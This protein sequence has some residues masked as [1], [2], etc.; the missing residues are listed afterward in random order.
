MTDSFLPSDLG[1]V[2][3]DTLDIGAQANSCS[4]TWG[5][6]DG[7]RLV[8]SMQLA[9]TQSIGSIGDGGVFTY[10]WTL[11]NTTN[12][13]SAGVGAGFTDALPSSLRVAAMP[14]AAS[15]CTAF[16][17]DALA[18]GTVVTV[19]GV[20]VPAG[21]TF[22]VSV[23]ITN[24]P[25]DSNASCAGNPAAFTNSDKNITDST[26]LENLIV[27]QCVLVGQTNTSLTVTKVA[28]S[29]PVTAGVSFDFVI[30]VTDTLD[31]IAALDV[32][33]TDILDPALIFNSIVASDSGTTDSGT[34][35]SVGPEYGCSWVSIPDG[36]SRTCTITVTP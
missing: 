11:D 32:V 22:T 28:S 4:D 6:V 14:N 2:D 5:F 30:T 13:D 1:L 25:G 10:T 26:G 8:P 7:I 18:G 34:T 31:G 12:A 29:D 33:V 16:T 15:T 36:L 21:S 24:V 9:K 3:G 35:D 27:P 17:I 19:S 20:E 23:D